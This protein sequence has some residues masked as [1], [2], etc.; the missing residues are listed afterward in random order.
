MV[1]ILATPPHSGSLANETVQ[2]SVLVSNQFA[3][4][5]MGVYGYVMG[6]ESSQGPK[7][8]GQ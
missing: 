6:D 3:V 8:E 4:F 1:I 7:E 2:N 5:D